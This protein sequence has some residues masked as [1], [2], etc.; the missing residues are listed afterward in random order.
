MGRIL[1]KMFLGFAISAI[2]I[3]GADNS[4]G[5]WKVDLAKSK[6]TPAPMPIK[7][8]TVTREA[9][10]GGVKVTSTGERS[11][12]SKI[13]SSYTAKYDGSETHVMGSGAP[14]DMIGV[15]Q[16]NANTFTEER[17]KMGGPYK[18]T[19]RMVISNDGKT[20]TTTA[21]G[22]NTEGKAFTSRFVFEKQ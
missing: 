19:A 22:T 3:F 1:T 17:S 11:D 14:Y 9:S 7:S 6:Y 2:A 5:T 8:L 4:L 16:V 10:D 15:K 12:G 18:A 20:M 13:D 21:K